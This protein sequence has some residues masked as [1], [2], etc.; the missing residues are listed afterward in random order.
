M[1][2]AILLRLVGIAAIVVFLLHMTAMYLH[3]YWTIIWF[4]LVVHALGG[5]WVALTLLWLVFHSNYERLHVFRGLGVFLVAIIGT[6]AVGIVWEFFELA[7]DTAVSPEIYRID[8]A[9]DLLMDTTGALIAYS[10]FIKIRD[11]HGA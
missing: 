3:L 7:T 6:L 5:L 8:T 10:F 1:K 2:N 11:S 4:D 9:L